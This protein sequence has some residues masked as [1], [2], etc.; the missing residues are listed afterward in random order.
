MSLPEQEILNA[1]VSNVFHIDDITLGDSGGE[2]IVRYRGRLALDSIQAFDQLTVQLRP[3]KLMPLFRK[4]QDDGHI[5]LITG[6]LPDPKPSRVWINLVLFLLTVL[7]VIWTGMLYT[8]P[9]QIAGA[10]SDL[11]VLWLRLLHG[12]L[13]FAVSLLGI[14]LAHEFG[15]YFV[16]RRHNT[17]A[18]LP[19]FIPFPTLLGTMGAVIVW[20]E[21]PRNK[22]VL[23]DVGI[24]GPLAG[25]VVAIPVVLYGLLLSKTGPIEPVSGGF[26]EGNSIL[27]LLSKYIIFG[28]LLPAPAS[29]GTISP[30]LYWLKFFFTGLP[31]PTGGTDVFISP[32][33]MAGWAGLLVTSLNLIPAGQLDGGHVMYVLF[34]KKLKY[35]LPVIIGLLALMGFFWSGWWLWVG[36][37]LFF[38]R[39]AADPLDQITELNPGRRA[40]AYFI[41]LVFVLVFIPVPLIL[42]G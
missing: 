12:G 21:L 7:S 9:E 19:Y 13:P 30:L 11:Q 8:E 33:A 1:L 5:I 22:R 20:K 36:L 18:S 2:F 31:V 24:A 17:A 26:I 28:Q 39:Q 35:A 34:G 38:G 15:H 16:T 3:Y 27:Y 37:L 25:L 32:V 41:I 14:L 23:F 6:S 4:G 29:Y 10:T 42:F 40:L